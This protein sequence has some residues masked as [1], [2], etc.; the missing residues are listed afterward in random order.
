MSFNPSQGNAL[1]A[2][3]PNKRHLKSCS[4]VNAT[5]RTCLPSYVL[6]VLRSSADVQLYDSEFQTEG[7]LTQNAFDDNVSGIRGAVVAT[8]IYANYCCSK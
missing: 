4:L 6:R 1:L 7:V 5:L 3:F 8:G 2:T